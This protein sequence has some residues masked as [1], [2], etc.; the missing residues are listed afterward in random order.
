MDDIYNPEVIH[1]EVVDKIIPI[2]AKEITPMQVNAAMQVL[3][4]NGIE[5]DEAATVLQA[6]GY[7]LLN[8]ELFPEEGD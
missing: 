7:V 6:L 8:T 1:D 2:E 4:D 5:E 3:I